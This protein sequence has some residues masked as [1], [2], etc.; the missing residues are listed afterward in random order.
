MDGTNRHISWLVHLKG[1]E[2]YAALLVT[3]EECLAS[4]YWVKIFLGRFSFVRIYLFRHLRPRLF[5]CRLKQS[6]PQ[7]VELGMDTM[8]LENDDV[9]KG[10]GIQPT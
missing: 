3:N 1:D 8:V 4:S 7:V 2:S 10:E 9:R 6:C 5:L